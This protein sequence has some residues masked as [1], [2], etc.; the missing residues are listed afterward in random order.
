MHDDKSDPFFDSLCR[1]CK[2]CVSRVIEPI[3]VESFIR[4]YEYFATDDI[5]EEDEITFGQVTCL[6]L[7][8]DLDHVVIECNKYEPESMSALLE[9]EL[10]KRWSL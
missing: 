10:L 2:H 8:V 5:N 9:T 7:Q 6:L 1:T 3:D 4:D